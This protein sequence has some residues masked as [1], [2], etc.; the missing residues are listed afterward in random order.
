MSNIELILI[1]FG[2]FALLWWG[3]RV[4]NNQNS[5]NEEIKVLRRRIKKLE[6]GK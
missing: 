6:V 1:A 3:N 2:F 5:L 4:M